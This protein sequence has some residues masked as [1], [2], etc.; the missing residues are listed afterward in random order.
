MRIH[1]LADNSNRP[2]I[3]TT[4][5][6]LNGGMRL[7]RIFIYV[8]S[9][10]L[11]SKTINRCSWFCPNSYGALIKSREKILF[12]KIKFANQIAIVQKIETQLIGLKKKILCYMHKKACKIFNM[13]ATFWITI[14]AWKVKNSQISFQKQCIFSLIKEIIIIVEYFQCSC[15][16]LRNGLIKIC[17]FLLG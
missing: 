10:P 5:S 9:C 12:A 11:K 2:Q 4:V 17:S 8:M 16:F 13:Y 14:Y 3:T 6:N 15:L 1:F 7:D